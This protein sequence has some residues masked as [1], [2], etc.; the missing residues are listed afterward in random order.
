MTSTESEDIILLPNSMNLVTERGIKHVV[1]CMRQEMQ[2]GSYSGKSFTKDAKHTGRYMIRP[3]S[4]AVD[5]IHALNT[6]RAFGLK[7]DAEFLARKDGPVA[8]GLKRRAQQ[9]TG[10]LGGLQKFID[11]MGR[12]L[13]DGQDMELLSEARA[14]YEELRRSAQASAGTRKA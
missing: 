1:Q 8:A 5:N 2:R 10:G 4:N 11:T 6:L 13:L 7:R 14:V 12:E 3:H 9:W